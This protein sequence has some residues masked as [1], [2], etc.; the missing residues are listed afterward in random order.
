MNQLTYL[1]LILLILS[2]NSTKYT[3]ENL[4]DTQL[5]FGQGGGFTGAVTSYC[6]LENGQLF[7]KSDKKTFESWK[8][9]K[10][11]KAKEIFK[12]CYANRLDTIEH[13]IPGNMYFFIQYRKDSIDNKILWNDNTP[14]DNTE[15]PK[16]YHSLKQ[17]T[18]N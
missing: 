15:I 11:K 1:V 13:S 5:I 16:L 12:N 8:K 9:V 3:A 18:I 14:P 6:L 10:K 17:L 7:K 2:C 4:P